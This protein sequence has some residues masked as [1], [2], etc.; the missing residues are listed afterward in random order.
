MQFSVTLWQK[1]EITQA[2]VVSLEEPI[3]CIPPPKKGG[4]TGLLKCKE[5][6]LGGGAG[7]GGTFMGVVHHTFDPQGQSVNQHL[8]YIVTSQHQKES[9]L[10]KN[11]SSGI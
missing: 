5:H 3:I 1:A 10:Q 11:L 4:K 2:I 6:A 7:E 8:L 9:V